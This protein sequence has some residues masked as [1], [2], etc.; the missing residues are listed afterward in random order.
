MTV[1]TNHVFGYQKPVLNFLAASCCYY[2]QCLSNGFLMVKLEFLQ[3]NVNPLNL[4]S[5]C[6]AAGILV[7]PHAASLKEH[8]TS[9]NTPF[10]QQ[11]DLHGTNFEEQLMPYWGDQL[12]T[13]LHVILVI[14][15]WTKSCALKENGR[16]LG[17]L[18]QKLQRYEISAERQIWKRGAEPIPY[19]GSGCAACYERA[20]Q[21]EFSQ[22]SLPP[23]RHV[24]TEPGCTPAHTIV[25]HS[26]TIMI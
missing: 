1:T 18:V 24:L 12:Y 8:I 9:K 10:T 19:L 7:P 13:F 4:R 16:P 21:P 15:I 26:Q 2:L 14:Q 25:L 22:L 23:M 6:I 3:Q 17:W 20:A 11:C 5:V